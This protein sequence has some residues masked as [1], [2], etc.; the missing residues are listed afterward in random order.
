MVGV[1]PTSLRES[2]K[3]KSTLEFCIPQ[4]YLFVDN[5][6]KTPPQWGSLFGEPCLSN[7]WLHS[8][9]PSSQH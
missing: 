3:N 2:E 1:A 5:V 7:Q 8:H 9:L 4:K 6:R